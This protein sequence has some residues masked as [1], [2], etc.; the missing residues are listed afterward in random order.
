MPSQQLLAEMGQYN[1]ALFEA[2]IMQDGA[3]L[4]PSSK[5][6]RVRFSG[7]NRT[8]VNGPFAETKELVAGFWMWE[9]QSMEQAIEWLKK[10][11]CPM[12]EEESD[13][14]LRPLFESEDFGEEFT[15]D[16]RA[17]EAEIE[18]ALSM[19]KASVQPYLFFG[20]RCAEAVAFYETALHAKRLMLMRYNESPE[21]IPPGMLAPGFENKVMHCSFQVGSTMIMASDGRDANSSMSGF[22]LTLNVPTEAD[23]DR[24]FNALALDGQ[25]EMPLAKTFWSPRF[26]MVKDKFGVT[27][28]VMVPGPQPN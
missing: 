7:V 20:G 24:V 18:A 5:G 22:Q 21:A 23:A 6:V 4:Q 3:G 10:C 1:Q 16:L 17:K 8:V 15:D 9:V 26:G 28:M 13:V 27:W 2:G 25:I 11:P 19:A 12:G 14:E